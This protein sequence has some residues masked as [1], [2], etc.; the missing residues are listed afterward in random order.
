M[1]L[2]EFD[3]LEVPWLFFKG[4]LY[5]P[6]PG[7]PLR[8]GGFETSMKPLR[9]LVKKED[10]FRARLALNNRMRSLNG[11]VEDRVREKY[12]ESAF[13]REAVAVGVAR[14]HS[15]VLGK[16]LRGN[17][18]GF[19]SQ[20]YECVK[21]KEGRF[22]NQNFSLRHK[23]WMKSVNQSYAQALSR[24][25][26]P[27]Q[28]RVSFE[29]NCAKVRLEPF[30]MRYEGKEYPMDSCTFR[31]KYDKSKGIIET[32]PYVEGEYDHP[33]VH[34][35]GEVCLNKARSWKRQGVI[36]EKGL[37]D[38]ASGLSWALVE[39]TRVLR[40]GYNP[41]VAVVHSLEN[42]PQGRRGGIYVN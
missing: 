29:G 33:F 19:R 26:P 35:D 25:I 31:I 5:V 42:F 18:L 2:K 40:E 36:P 32:F 4:A 22:N 41:K 34:H 14:N 30:T 9:N 12:Y 24:D 10:E 13:P 3:E 8:V 38:L 23:G 28:S 21:G 11:S 1:V 15:S 27:Q 16:I 7:T 37:D 6:G 39:T 17:H 20:L